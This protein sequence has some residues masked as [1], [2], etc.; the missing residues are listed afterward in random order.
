VYRSETQDPRLFGKFEDARL[1]SQDLNGGDVRRLVRLELYQSRNRGDDV[2][3]GYMQ[4]TLDKL[5]TLHAGSQL[6]WWPVVQGTPLS[7]VKVISTKVQQT[8]SW[9]VLRLAP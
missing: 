6:Y 3:L 4:T 2:L 5:S 7:R 1:V 8:E 9:F